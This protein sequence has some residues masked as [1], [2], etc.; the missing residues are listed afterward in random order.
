MDNKVLIDQAV[1]FHFAYR[2][3]ERV[4]QIILQPGAPWTEIA[5]VLEDFKVEFQ[6]LEQQAKEAEKNKQEAS[7]PLTVEAESSVE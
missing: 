6:K 3:N 2:K 7:E 1:L 4:Y 5:E